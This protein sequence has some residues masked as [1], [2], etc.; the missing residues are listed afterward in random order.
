M[1]HEFVVPLVTSVLFV[2]MLL[3]LETAAASASVGCTMIPAPRRK[4][5]AAWTSSTRGWV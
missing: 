1:R 3:R 4:E 5:S 2:S